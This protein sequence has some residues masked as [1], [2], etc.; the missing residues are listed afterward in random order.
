MQL[1]CGGCAVR[2]NKIHK[3]AKLFL[4]DIITKASDHR[5]LNVN[6]I[7]N[8]YLKIYHQNIKRERDVHRSTV[9]MYCY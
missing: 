5:D 7:Y 2:H 3:E 6:V 4:K 1:V 9:N 8:Y